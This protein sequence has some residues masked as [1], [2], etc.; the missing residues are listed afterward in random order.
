[1]SVKLISSSPDS[2]VLSRTKLHKH[3][4]KKRV[5]ERDGVRCRVL[6][7]SDLPHL[8]IDVR[9]ILHLSWTQCSLMSSL[10]SHNFREAVSDLLTI[11]MYLKDALSRFHCPSQEVDLRVHVT[12]ASTCSRALHELQRCFAVH[13]TIVPLVPRCDV[14]ANSTNQCH[15]QD[16][17]ELKQTMFCFLEEAYTGYHVSSTLPNSDSRVASILGISIPISSHHQDRTFWC[18]RNS[19]NIQSTRNHVAR[20]IPNQISQQTLDDFVTSGSC[21]HVSGQLT[22]CVFD[23]KTIQPK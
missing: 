9:Q 5:H 17:P 8:R 16:S 2:D 12:S 13:K 20:R 19:R 7:G 1:M 15:Q 4:N 11:T 6:V 14:L 18:A 22:D 3:V 10:R 21:A 23:V